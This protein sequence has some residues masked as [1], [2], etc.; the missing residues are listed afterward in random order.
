M[1][2]SMN[3][4]IYDKAHQLACD[5]VN[6]SEV[7]DTQAFWNLYNELDQLCCLNENGDSNHPFQWETLADFTTDNAASILIY[8]KAFGVAEVLELHEYMASIRFAIAERLHE[9]KLFEQ[10]Y[11][12]AKCADEYARVTDDVELRKE[13]SGFLLNEGSHS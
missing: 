11:S 13:I 10:A 1:S 4:G 2:A 12:S 3:P 8:E 5:L 7:N 6:A 9:L